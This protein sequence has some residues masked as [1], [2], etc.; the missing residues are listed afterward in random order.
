MEYGKHKYTEYSDCGEERSITYKD[1]DEIY[2]MLNKNNS[3]LFRISCF[4]K[5]LVTPSS[6]DKFVYVI[7]DTYKSESEGNA[8]NIQCYKTCSAFAKVYSI[9][10][11]IFFYPLFVIFTLL[12]DY[13]EQ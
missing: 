11:W 2:E 12:D 7:L 13:L 1:I 9:I 10:F 5:F 8:Y 3:I 6:L 4:F